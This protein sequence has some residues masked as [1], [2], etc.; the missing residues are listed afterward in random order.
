MRQRRRLSECSEGEGLQL[1]LIQ[2]SVPALLCPPGGLAPSECGEGAAAGAIWRQL[3]AEEGPS[4][5]DPPT[6]TCC[7][8]LPPACFQ[9][10]I[11]SSISLFLFLP[12]T[13]PPALD[14]P[15]LRVPSLALA[16]PSPR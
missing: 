12:Q 3:S 10:P 4:A 14:F 13:P 1:S 2:P 6:G 7:P 11:A 5:G 16:P 8:T 15:Q 9:T